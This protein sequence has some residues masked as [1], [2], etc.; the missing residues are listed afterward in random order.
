MKTRP[1]NQCKRAGFT[2]AAANRSFQWTA[3]HTTCAGLPSASLRRHRIQTLAAL[4]NPMAPSR[5]LH[6]FGLNQRCGRGVRV[7]VNHCTVS[8][9]VVRKQSDLL[10]G[11]YAKWGG[12]SNYPFNSLAA[13]LAACHFKGS[14]THNASA[15][16]GASQNLSRFGVKCGYERPS[17]FVRA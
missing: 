2:L 17:Q 6:R 5:K 8:A 14:G 10:A 1:F 12:V 7:K 16:R 13:R 15:C 4:S 9:L 11:V 3:H